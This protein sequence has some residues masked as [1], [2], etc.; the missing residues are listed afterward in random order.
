MSLPKIIPSSDSPTTRDFNALQTRWASILN[1][2]I[3]QINAGDGIFV[4]TVLMWGGKSIPDGYLICDGQVVLQSQYADLFQVIGTTFNTGGEPAGWFRIPPA[5]GS[6]ILMI[7][8][9]P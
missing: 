5:S 1:P 8:F 4:G 9:T 6:F 7:K 3:D 2:V